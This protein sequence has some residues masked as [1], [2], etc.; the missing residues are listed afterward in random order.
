MHMIFT[1]LIN[2][3]HYTREQKL[4]AKPWVKPLVVV[5]SLKTDM[6]QTLTTKFEKKNTC[7]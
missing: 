4:Q 7:I 6:K 1:E 3:P 5:K 2:L